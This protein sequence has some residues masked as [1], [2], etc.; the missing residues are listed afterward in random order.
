MGTKRSGT[1]NNKKTTEKEFAMNNITIKDFKKLLKT[2]ASKFEGIVVSESKISKGPYTFFITPLTQ[3]EHKVDV[4]SC[5]YKSAPDTQKTYLGFVVD[6]SDIHFYSKVFSNMFFDKDC[7]DTDA[8]RAMGK[9]LYDELV[10]MNPVAKE[11]AYCRYE[12]NRIA[13]CRAVKGNPDYDNP[14]EVYGVIVCFIFRSIQPWYSKYNKFLVDYLANPTGWAE[15]SIHEADELLPSIGINPFSSSM[16]ANILNSERLAQKLVA[17][18]SVP[19]TK[20]E[21]YKKLYRSVSGHDYVQLLI[22]I[23]GD[24]ISLEYPVESDLTSHTLV[25]EEALRTFVAKKRPS[26]KQ[27]VENFLAK[28]NVE[29]ATRIPVKYIREIYTPDMKNVL[30]KNPK[31]EGLTK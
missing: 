18:Y 22:E 24:T 1:K 9:A 26:K 21:Y 4:L 19:G 28:H 12:G 11:N 14:Y 20:E 10:K 5:Q 31:F 3:G 16:G 17:S 27:K 23:D 30:W 25:I 2:G 7:D 13:F 6:S 8:I 15:R 29:F